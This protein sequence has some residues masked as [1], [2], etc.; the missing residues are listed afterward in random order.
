MAVR[1]GVWLV[2]VLIG[3]A[4]MV[5]A[6]GLLLMYTAVGREPQIAGNSTL[7]LRIDGDLPEMESAS[8]FG[9]FFE[10]PPTVRSIVFGS[11]SM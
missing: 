2:L 7:V 10:S 4:V 9:Q 11:L 8:V 3:L 5:S 6:A 1:R